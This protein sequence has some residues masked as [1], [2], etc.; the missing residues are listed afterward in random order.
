[1]EEVATS[2]IQFAIKVASEGTTGPWL[3]VIYICGISALLNLAID[4]RNGIHARV[5]APKPGLA[6]TGMRQDFESGYPQRRDSAQIVKSSVDAA[7]KLRGLSRHIERSEKGSIV[8]SLA[9]AE[10]VMLPAHEQSFE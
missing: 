10:V 1:M 5:D 8:P 4:V 2:T 9:F 6:L 7:R 3:L